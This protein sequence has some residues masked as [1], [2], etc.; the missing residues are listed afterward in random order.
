MTPIQNLPDGIFLQHIFPFLHARSTQRLWWIL[1]REWNTKPDWQQL[2]S[3]D[4]KHLT[5]NTQRAMLLFYRQLTTPVFR[6][7]DVKGIYNKEFTNQ[8]SHTV[9]STYDI[10]FYPSV[11]L[12][13]GLCWSTSRSVH[14]VDVLH[15][16]TTQQQTVCQFDWL[17]LPPWELPANRRFMLWLP[18]E[19]NYVPPY[20]V[21]LVGEPE[22]TICLTN[23]KCVYRFSMQDTNKSSYTELVLGG[24]FESSITHLRLLCYSYPYLVVTG[25]PLWYN[26][27]SHY[28]CFGIWDIEKRLSVWPE[29]IASGGDFQSRCGIP[30]NNDFVNYECI[31]MTS[32]GKWLCWKFQHTL[33]RMHLSTK[34]VQ[35]TKPFVPFA[36]GRVTDFT[37]CPLKMWIAVYYGDEDVWRL[38]DMRKYLHQ[39]SP[40]DRRPLHTFQH[41]HKTHMCI[42]P[43]R[44]QFQFWRKVGT[45]VLMSTVAY[46]T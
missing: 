12:P 3:N 36:H 40:P 30:T 15:P 45:K 25:Q 9:T 24:R 41:Q 20:I 7:A 19:Q 8:L 34:K 23:F 14:W 33:C 27:S 4:D 42:H 28:K 29:V 21:S 10:G 39:D 16:D 46:S 6:L 2:L 35:C 26:A 1:A 44:S 11:F 17:V 22:D 5:P 43:F 18:S 38:F 31:H 13:R 32:C 37:I